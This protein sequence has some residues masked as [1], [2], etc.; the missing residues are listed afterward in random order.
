MSEKMLLSGDVDAIKEF[1]FET[2]FLP[3]IRGG[4]QL[5]IDCEDA[6]K[7]YANGREI[8][9][10]GGGGFL[11]EMPLGEIDRA[12][13]DIEQIYLKN[14]YA[15]TV[16]IAS[17]QESLLPEKISTLDS[18]G[19]A[20]LDKWASRIWMDATQ[21]KYREDSF[22]LKSSFLSMKVRECKQQ[23]RN[24]P[25]MEA[26]PFGDRCDC[27]GKRMASEVIRLKKRDETE[28]METLKVCRVCHHK[29][30]RGRSGDYG[31]RGKFNE[32]F[33]NFVKDKIPIRSSQP[34]DLDGLV[35]G[36]KRDYLAFIYA[37][38]NNIGDL[39]SQAGS[40]EDYKAISEGLSDGTRDSLFSALFHVCGPALMKGGYWP[41]EII[42]VGGDD[43]TLLIQA[44]YAW[45]V[46]I[47]FLENFGKIIPAY[48][49][50]KLGEFPSNW[51]ITAS[52]GI[53]I[54][55]KSYRTCLAS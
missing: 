25:F 4:S 15:A 21:Q 16:T 48:I 23:K 20:R 24:A 13:H 44:G 32:Y 51:Q 22:G 29:H 7:K 35:Q 38:G 45:E 17:E 34:N 9:C 27:C 43:V 49:E 1:V 37:D 53:S 30:E 54:A 14:T 19:S 10:G 33:S 3:Q 2:S 42:N 39:L 40:K 6:V 18:E 46:A 31:T 12:K 28:P 55:N 8:Y 41:F 47:E 50:K 5:L 26:L 36:S 52:C 11:I